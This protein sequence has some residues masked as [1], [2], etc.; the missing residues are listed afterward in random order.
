VLAVDDL[1][2]A[3]HLDELNG[4]PWSNTYLNKVKNAVDATWQQLSPNGL[5]PAIGDTYRLGGS[6][7]FLRAALALNET[8]W[9][10]GKPRPRDAWVFGTSAIALHLNNLNNPALGDRSDRVELRDS[11]NFVLRS[12]DDTSAR[13][14]NFKA[15]PKGGIHGH[16]DLLNFE[17][18]GSGRPLIADPGA[19]LYDNS[20][21]RNYVMSTKAHNTIGV[22]DTNHG[23]LLN[24]DSILVSPLSTI[25]GGTMISASHQAYSYLPGS[26]TI[27]RSL[28]YDGN[29]TLV[30][31]DFVAGT[32]ARNYEAS[33][34]LQN[35]NTFRDLSNGLIY[36]RNTDGLGNVRIQSL[37]RA[38]QT[39]GIQTTNAFTTSNPPP[40]ETDPATRYFVQQKNT[41]Y[42][43]FA[44]VITAH[45]GNTANTATATA[46]WVKVPKR[47]GQSAILNINGNNI[48]FLP[49]QFQTPQ[50]EANVRGTGNDIAYDAGGRLHLVYYDR[51]A[52]NL[53]YAVRDTNGVWSTI[54]TIDS[55]GTKLGINLSLALDSKGR[56]GVAYQ[57]GQ[58]GDL[59]YAYFSPASNAWEVQKVDVKGSTGGYP[60]LAFT[61]KNGA[62]IAYYNKTNGDLRLATSQVDGWAIETIDR[63]GDVGRFASLVLDPN[64]PTSSK[65][66]IAYEDTTKA[67]VKWALQYK[68]GWRYETID[69]TLGIA[70]GYISMGFYDSGATTDRYKAAASYYDA[71]RGQLRYAY[72]T[73]GIESQL[74]TSQA[75]ATR[76]R[77]G[78]YSQLDLTGNKPR[79][80]FYDGTNKRALMLRGSKI[81]GGKWTLTD[82]GPGGREIKFAR[83]NGTYTFTNL[84]ESVGQLI[85]KNI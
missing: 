35:Q 11:G 33:F 42:A 75:I 7:I 41:T 28:W 30:V 56:P 78:L 74:W 69:N 60:D 34:N 71:T 54:Q 63:K 10:E 36:S 31:V 61:R 79:V 59:R 44:H 23:E 18:W 8:R 76:K 46:S 84:N 80:F 4:T 72:D 66:A 16:F 45:A 14:I 25:A 40:N 27:Q 68:S 1:I 64:R 17:F 12:G 22:T 53:K 5:R 39:A 13:Q 65:F 77:Q 55:D 48:S 19:Y 43:V 82:L 26:P 38:G 51:D 9:P 70:G 58:N 21:K 3:L 50:A 52:Q 32:R 62:A 37:L 24:N 67:D 57:D 2:E 73:G 81:G 47:L 83:Y 29:N 85:V 49:P 20:S 15:G 6:T